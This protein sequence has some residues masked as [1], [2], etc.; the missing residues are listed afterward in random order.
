MKINEIEFDKII[1]EEFTGSN[2]CTIHTQ[3]VKMDGNDK[4]IHL[5]ADEK[6]LLE[7]KDTPNR[8]AETFTECISEVTSL[9]F[10]EVASSVVINE[11]IIMESLRT[12][13]QVTISIERN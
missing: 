5:I 9:P 1:N 10:N 11:D 8:L 2:G 6:V 4:V 13:N 3:L 12:K 7:N